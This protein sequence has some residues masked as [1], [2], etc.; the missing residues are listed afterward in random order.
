L[1]KKALPF[2]AAGAAEMSDKQFKWILASCGVRDDARLLAKVAF[3]I[4]SPRITALNLPNA[5]CFGI[6]SECDFNILVKRFEEEC[7][8]V[9]Y[10]NKPVLGVPKK[11][12]AAGEKRGAANKGGS[13][14]AK[15][16]RTS[17]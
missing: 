5:D 2:K 8:K 15:K 14:A 1:T 3:G 17:K 12:P 9:G 4:R 10:K 16:P 7:A 11:T 13:A 6:L